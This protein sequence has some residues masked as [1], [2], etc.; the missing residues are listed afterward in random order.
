MVSWG[1]VGRENL[2]TTWEDL[3]LVRVDR[4]MGSLGPFIKEHMGGG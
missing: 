4:W 3:R 2:Q 1:Q